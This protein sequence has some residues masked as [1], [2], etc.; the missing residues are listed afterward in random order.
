MERDTNGA[1]FSP[2]FS[3]FPTDELV[4]G[5]QEVRPLGRTKSYAWT[6]ALATEAS[7]A[8]ANDCASLDVG[9]EAP[10]S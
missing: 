10:T 8:K 6:L 3:P 4:I 5:V 2:N 1:E 9:A 7:V